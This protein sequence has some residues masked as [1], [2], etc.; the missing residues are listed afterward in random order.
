[1]PA[2]VTLPLS[3]HLYRSAERLAVGDKRPVQSLL[4]DLLS[5]ALGVW[6]SEDDPIQGWP[7]ERVVLV[8]ESQMSPRQSERLGELLDKQQ[9][10]RLTAEER[11]ELWTLTRIYELGQLRKAEAL[12]EA[13]RRGLR[14][15]SGS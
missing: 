2:Y 1:M 13:V 9:A 11:P 3:D 10:G 12:A 6:E 7:D 14:S 8:C 5:T 4:A 15:P